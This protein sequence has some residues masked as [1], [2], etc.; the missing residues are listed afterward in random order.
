M[1]PGQPPAGTHV[2]AARPDRV[3]L[4]LDPSRRGSG[5]P[6]PLRGIVFLRE[7]A[8]GP[9]LE[10]ATPAVA[11]A[12]L[13]HLN[14]RLQSSAGRARSFTQ[15]TSLADRVP[16]WNLYRPMERSSLPAAVALIAERVSAVLR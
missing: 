10:R 4:G 14:F 9:R 12:D 15:L 1:Y 7:A 3:F 13:W 5:G 11:V 2:I 8:D 16:V 6:V